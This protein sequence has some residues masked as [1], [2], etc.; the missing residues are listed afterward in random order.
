V[1]GVMLCLA[2]VSLIKKGMIWR[3]DDVIMPGD[4]QQPGVQNNQVH[5][6]NRLKYELLMAVLLKGTWRDIDIAGCKGGL[7]S[8][9]FFYVMA[10]WVDPC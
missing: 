7:A 9:R 4:G 2:S 8:L 1:V 6:C 3:H 5:D 10:V